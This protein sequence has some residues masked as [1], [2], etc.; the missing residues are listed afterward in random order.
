MLVF[1]FKISEVTLNLEE[2]YHFRESLIY[3]YKFSVQRIKISLVILFFN[4]I[5]A[6]YFI[7]QITL[8]TITIFVILFLL[9][10]VLIDLVDFRISQKEEGED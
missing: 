1:Y 6:S 10:A 8:V 5:F 4:F 2:L 3:R 7:K 9:Y